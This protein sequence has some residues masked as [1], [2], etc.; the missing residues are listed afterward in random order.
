MI[1]SAYIAGGMLTLGEQMQRAMERDKIKE[2]GIKL[3]NPMDNKDINDKQALKDDTGLA[4]KIVF[5]DTNAILTSDVAIIEP[6]PHALGT[7]V[8]LGQIYMFNMLHEMFSNIVNNEMSSEDK[9]LEMKHLLEKYPHKQVFPHMQDVRRHDAPEVG[10]RRSWGVNQYVYG[11]CL[12]LTDGK[13]F[14]SY[15]EIWKALEQLNEQE[16]SKAKEIVG[17]NVEVKLNGKVVMETAIKSPHGKEIHN[18]NDIMIGDFVALKSMEELEDITYIDDNDLMFIDEVETALYIPLAMA[19]TLGKKYKVV[20][21]TELNHLRFRD[22]FNHTWLVD[23][24]LIKFAYENPDS[25]LRQK[26]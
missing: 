22:E 4:E 20:H 5:A 9:V 14:Y 13:G 25:L 19:H 8:E 26:Q 21:R 3:Y 11:V 16:D 7:C 12:D 2:L 17:A 6:M 24:N 10:D 1:K 15:N 23:S 18:Y